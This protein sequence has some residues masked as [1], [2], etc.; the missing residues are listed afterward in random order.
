MSQTLELTPAELEII[1]INR[2]K[3]A[4][5]LAEAKA[6]NQIK[7]E[8][9][10]LECKAEVVKLK[11]D[12]ESQLTAA[13]TYC[14][15]LGKGW[16]LKITTK[17]AERHVID[18]NAPKDKDDNYQIVYKEEYEDKTATIVNGEYYVVVKEHITY[19]S[20]WSFRGTNNGWKMYLRGPEVDYK[21]ENKAITKAATI[22]KKVDELI[23]EKQAKINLNIKQ[24]DT[25]TV[26]VIKIQELYP[27]A[28]VISIKEWRKEQW[29]K[30]GHEIDVVKIKFS[31]GVSSKWK[32]YNDGSLSR[33]EVNFGTSTSWDTMQALNSIA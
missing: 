6:V 8:K 28:E 1:K 20:K 10:I 21:Y 9:N 24:Y 12:I 14:D 11:K 31:N 19:T 23:E 33:L 7:I 32:V 13:Q 5:A 4:L 15:S 18:Y 3:D 27:D 16:T 30:Q 17:S 2:E 26:T 22:N 29:E 25:V